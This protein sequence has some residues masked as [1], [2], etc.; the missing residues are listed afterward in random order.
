[1]IPD[2]YLGVRTLLETP[3]MDERKWAK[4]PDIAT[5]AMLVDLE[6]SVPPPLK[7]AARERVLQYLKTPEFFGGRVLVARSNHLSTPWG[8]D[9]LIALAEAGVECLAYPK[10]RDAEELLEVQELLRSHGADPDLFGVV[11]TA[12]SV[13]DAA[14]IAKV[15]KVVAIG[16][17]AGDL[18]ADMGIPLYEDD[19]ELNRVFAPAKAQVT[20][21]A[22]AFDCLAIDFAYAPDLRDLDEIRRRMVD[23]R[24]LGFTTGA[25]F[26]PPHVA[27]INEVFTPTAEQ[28]AE[29]DEI[30][31]TYEAAV[32]AGNPA[33]ATEAGK[34]ILVHDYDKARKV[35]A[36]SDAIS[37]SLA[38]V[39]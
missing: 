16:L 38:G 2:R 14:A 37:R 25:T 17:G 35:R 22:A 20:L 21:A 5:D 24:R 6:D 18:S 32:A 34:T 30:I 1:M 29:A 31:G 28:L 23:S 15:D 27:V 39:A 33:V 36:K 3:I 13:L 7:E 8:R 9:D 10:C 12:R 19:G 4:V 11:E 26:Y